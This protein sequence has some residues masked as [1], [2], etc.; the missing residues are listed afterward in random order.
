MT[1]HPS[2]LAAAELEAGMQ[3]CV[4]GLFSISVP[5][6]LPTLHLPRWWPPVSSAHS[7]GCCLPH[8]FTQAQNSASKTLPLSWPSIP[9]QLLLMLLIWAHVTSS[10]WASLIARTD[11]ILL[12][13]LLSHPCPSSSDVLHQCTHFG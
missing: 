1:L 7:S 4:N 6:L 2:Y 10:R 11:A 13:H 12:T 8:K 3:A 9:N 5:R